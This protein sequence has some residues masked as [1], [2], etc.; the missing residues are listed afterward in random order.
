MLARAVA[1]LPAME[2]RYVEN[3]TSLYSR[4]IPPAL[5]LTLT[6]CVFARTLGYDFI[7]SWDDD[8][9]VTA[10][11]A[12]RGFSLH[13]LKLAFTTNYGG[14]YAPVQII[15]Y[16]IDYTFWE[17]N[18]S[19]YHLSNIIIHAAGGV[20][21]FHLLTRLGL[22][23]SAA[24]TAAALFLI[25]PVQVES[26]AWISQRKNVLA[27][28]FLLASFQLYLEFRCQPEGGKR[29][30]FYGAS[31]LCAVLALLSKSVAVVIPVLFLLYE[32]CFATSTEA[33]GGRGRLL[34]VLPAIAPF[35]FAAVAVALATVILQQADY[36]GGRLSFPV[37][38]AVV[39]FSMP[40][41]I[42]SYLGLIFF[43]ST[44]KLCNIYLPEL[45]DSF[46]PGLL[47]GML[48]IALLVVLGIILFRR[49]R[50]LF[51]WYATAWLAFLP[52]SQILPLATLMNDRYLYVP[53]IGITPLVVTGAM[54]AV[55]RIR[56]ERY[57][58]VA[59]GLICV[60]FAVISTQRSAV[61]KDEFTLWSDA[62]RK[63]PGDYQAMTVLANVLRNRGD[64][65]G[66]LEL[67]QKA[68]HLNP[69]FPLLLKSLGEFHLEKGD[70]HAARDYFRRFTLV[71][72]RNAAAFERYGL[73]S[74]LA[75]DS[76]EAEQAFLKALA[77]EAAITHAPLHLSNIYLAQGDVPAA[78][79]YL[80]M[81]IRNGLDGLE[82]SFESA[83]LEA[84]SGNET[85][86]F[87]HLEE[88][89]RLGFSDAA[90]LLNDPFLAP[91]RKNPER[92]NALIRSM[93]Q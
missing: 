77:M 30:F 7:P 1:A 26:V 22:S 53:M 83:C 71:S 34:R 62:Q 55:A 86:A 60:V 17:L 68:S 74:K 28:F 88:A 57:A 93:R 78:R 54:S 51:F 50:T 46:T 63:N 14:N 24:F 72:P 87:R 31:L 4:V 27:L 13:N 23:R 43:P 82:T 79:R 5:L 11:E 69:E 76:A 2:V 64:D 15:S 36:G 66:A 91:L 59:I 40:G 21:F 38:R 19:G 20:L 37:S 25:H 47:P 81:S 73:A 65:Q 84:Q 90:A 80:E 18:P 29:H 61:W 48:L 16:M 49:N 41:V 67:Y 89:V 39:V 9:Y 8:L 10:N 33:E 52:V 12:V 85:L 70:V 45:H 6:F 75:G 3:S 56:R 35:F 92:I 58:L 32:S 42:L 44:G